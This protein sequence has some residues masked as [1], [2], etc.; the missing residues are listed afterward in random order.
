MDGY[1]AAGMSTSDT[2]A[3]TSVL[4]SPF[5]AR[6]AVAGAGAVIL[7]IGGLTGT[8]AVGIGIGI[9]TAALAAAAMSRRTP[10]HPAD[11]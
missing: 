1:G 6:L 7:V 11:E 10:A 8:L 3:R 2:G 9:T 5:R 4:G